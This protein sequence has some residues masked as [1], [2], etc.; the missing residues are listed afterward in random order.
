MQFPN[1]TTLGTSSLATIWAT[2][3]GIRLRNPDI[4]DPTA[5][6]NQKRCSQL[7]T[8]FL[9]DSEKRARERNQSF[10]GGLRG[11][12]RGAG[13]RFGPSLVGKRGNTCGSYEARTNQGTT[14][15]SRPSAGESLEKLN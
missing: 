8:D 5:Y 11:P 9:K 3:R 6:N 1:N 2:A 15:Q 10:E 14:R 12:G 13:G 4:Y 7:V